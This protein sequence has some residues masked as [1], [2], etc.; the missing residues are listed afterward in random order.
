MTR[1]GSGPRRPY[2]E[3]M[4]AHIERSARAVA[5]VSLLA[6]AAFFAWYGLALGQ[7][8]AAMLPFFGGLSLTW[9]V[10]A[11]GVSRQRVWGPSYAAGLAA[12][13]AMVMLPVGLHPAVIAFL[14]AQVIL[15]TALAVRSVAAHDAGAPVASWRHSGVGFMAGVAVPWIVVAGLMPTGATGTL[16]IGTGAAAL[17]VAGLSGVFRGKTWGLFATMAAIPALIAIPEGFGCAASSHDRAGELAALALGLG[18][19]PWL[20]PLARAL[21]PRR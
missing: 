21:S 12:I 16:L 6:S 7:S 1:I 15:L 13:S 11:I 2:L 19:L 14:G 17:A 4:P 5:V 18:L 20:A 10:G 3:G 9:L 8:W